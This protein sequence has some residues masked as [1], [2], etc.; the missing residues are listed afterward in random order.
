VDTREFI[1]FCT[2]EEARLKWYAEA[3][4]VAEELLAVK[5]ET[6][7]TVQERD[8]ALADRDAAVADL[9]AKK[10]KYQREG[11]TALADLERVIKEKTDRASAAT[12]RAAA[13]L[14][15]LRVETEAAH[16]AKTEADIAHRQ[17]VA[18]AREEMTAIGPAEALRAERSYQGAHAAALKE[19]AWPRF[20]T[21]TPVRKRT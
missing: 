8:K 5:K 13:E 7:Q 10:E 1:E 17:F 4:G 19:A 12:A 20:S 16:E 2:R 3:R 6:E 14:A 11:E 21:F 15:Q 9:E 18:R